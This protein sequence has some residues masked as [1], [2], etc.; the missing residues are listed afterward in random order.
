[1]PQGAATPEAK[2]A[3]LELGQEKTPKPVRIERV[4]RVAWWVERKERGGEGMEGKR[5][6][7]RGGK[8][9]GGV[10]QRG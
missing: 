6:E 5:K 10:D 8:G 2:D 7:G 3:G 1:M 4:E 9:R